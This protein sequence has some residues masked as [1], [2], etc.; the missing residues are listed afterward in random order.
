MSYICE[1]WKNKNNG[2]C[3]IQRFNGLK[4]KNIQNCEY[5]EKYINLNPNLLK[6]YSIEELLDEI[7]R[8]VNE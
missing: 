8:R 6:D 7:R 5:Y 3:N 1:D 2:W 4:K